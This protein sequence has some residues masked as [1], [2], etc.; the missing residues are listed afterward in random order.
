MST[1]RRRARQ[2]LQHGARVVLPRVA[3]SVR[4]AALSL[5]ARAGTG[6]AVLPGPPPGPVLV[7]SAHPDDETIGCGGAMIRHAEAGDT[8]TVLVATSGEATAGGGAQGVG[9]AR[10][11][12][13]RA[14]C[15]ALGVDP[16]VF[17]RLPDGGLVTRVEA[18]TDAVRRHGTGAAVVYVPSPMD[19]HPDHRAV[20][21]AVAHAG[22]EA[23]VMGYELW[24]AASVDV[25]LDIG[26]VY[27]RKEEALRCYPVALESVDYVGAAR[28]LAAYRGITAG[29]GR[30][31][32][33][34][35][36]VRMG[37]REH[38]A[39]IARLPAV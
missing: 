28:G 27:L 9:P 33:A 14:A 17:L 6:P 7:V 8:V 30:Q 4:E 34:E 16:P 31:G 39:L 11:A 29:L 18:V 5:A 32:L 24:S 12:E 1:L 25:V 13:C 35:G 22:L 19:P 15:A 23:K 36:F 21:R 26:A 10:E 20:A 38:A 2:A 37:A 3:P